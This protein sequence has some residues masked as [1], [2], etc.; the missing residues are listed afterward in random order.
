M[1]FNFYNMKNLIQTSLV[2]AGL[3]L[4]AFNANAA[5]RTWTGGAVLNDL[6]SDKDNW[7]G[8]VAPVSGDR[9]VF[10]AG[11]QDSDKGMLNTF[12]S[13]TVFQRLTFNAAGYTVSGTAVRLSG[14]MVLEYGVLD[15]E[16]R[17]DVPL[18]LTASQ[19]LDRLE[20][21]PTLHLRPGLTGPAL[22]L[23]A[24][25]LTVTGDGR[26]I[27]EGEV[28][29]TGGLTVEGYEVDL[30]RANS[31]TGLTLIQSNGILTLTDFDVAFAPPTLGSTAGPTHVHG[32]LDFAFGRDV[33]VAEPLKIFDGGMVVAT[34]FEAAN[35]GVVTHT[36]SLELGGPGR[37][38][39][40]VT[41]SAPQVLF[42]VNGVISGNGD[43]VK[44][45]DPNAAI[46]D[47]Q[48]LSIGG[49]QPNSFAG[50]YHAQANTTFLAKPTGV[51]ALSCASVFIDPPY[52]LTSRLRL[53]ASHQIAD[54][55]HVI[56]Q[57]RGTF[58]LQTR[59]ETIRALTLAGGAVNGNAPGQLDVTENIFSTPA[60]QSGL[61]NA[62]VHLYA[63]PCEINVL[64]GP[65]LEDLIFTGTIVDEAGASIRK[66]GPGRVNFT[67][68]AT[69]PVEIVEGAVV[70]QR[71]PGSRI[72]LNGG[73]LAGSGEIGLLTSL[74]GGGRV[75]PGYSIGII[76]NTTIAW[77]S[78]TTY[79]VEVLNATP[80][81]GHDQLRVL[82]G[83]V[84]LGGAHLEV[85]T[86]PGFG[87]ALGQEF[88]IIDNDGSDAIT[89]TFAGLTNGAE[90]A[91]A[92]GAK[93]TVHYNGG[94]GNDVSLRTTFVPPTGVT[95]LWTGD[96]LT[97][98]W[99]SGANW[100]AAI[101]PGDRLQFPNSAQ[102]NML[103][104]LPAFTP[105]DTL[106][107]SSAGYK[108]RG[109]P[110]ALINGL[111]ANFVGVPMLLSNQF[112]LLASNTTFALSGSAQ[113]E[114]HRPTSPGSGVT[115]DLGNNVL[116]LDTASG[117]TRLMFE[118]GESV[119][120]GAGLVVKQGIGFLQLRG[121]SPDFTGA[122]RV[123]AGTL[124]LQD[125]VNVLGSL[126]TAT[127]TVQASATLDMAFIG[128]LS[129]PQTVRLEAGARLRSSGGVHSL[130][131]PL[132][133]TG[134]PTRPIIEVAD[135]TLRFNQP[136]SGTNGLRKTGAGELVFQGAAPNT[137][138]GPLLVEAGLLTLQKTPGVAA[139]GGQAQ[140]VGGVLRLGNGS[141]FPAGSGLTVNAPG[142]FDLNTRSE[143][144]QGG[145]GLILQGGVVSNGTLNVI[146]NLSTLA[147]PTA[148]RIEGILRVVGDPLWTVN[149]GA[150]EDDLIVNA[151]VGTQVN[152]NV[153]RA[154]G[155]RLVFAGTNTFSSL[156]L[157]AGLT[158]INGSNTTRVDLN[159]GTLGG[160][161][162]LANLTSL[163]GGGIV[164]PGASTGILS[165][166]NVSW[167]AATTFAPEIRT[168][169]PGAGHDQL[170]VFGSV[171]LGGATLDVTVLSNFT[172]TTSDTIVL[173][174]N[175]GTEAITN[176]FAG[177][178]EGAT[179]TEAELGAGTPRSFRISYV[180]GA[181]SNDVTLKLLV[182]G[183]GLTRTWDGGGTNNNWSVSTN[184]DGNLTAPAA[185]DA[186]VFPIGAARLLNT[187]NFAAGTGFDSITIRSNGY[188]LR[189]NRVSLIQ[190]LVFDHSASSTL[191]LPITLTQP[192]SFTAVNDAFGIVAPQG[193]GA[194]L[195]NA[196]F[197]LTLRPD[198]ALSRVD[199]SG[200]TGSGALVKNGPGLSA[201]TLNTHSGLTTINEG[202]VLLTLSADGLGTTA[203]A[204]VVNANALVQFS[205]VTAPTLA[206]PFKLAG[207]LAF[208]NSPVALTAP[209][210]LVGGALATFHVSSSTPFL[211]GAISGSG[212][213]QKTG[214][215]ELILDGSAA[216][217][218]T[219]GTTIA[220]GVLHLQKTAGIAALPGPVFITGGGGSAELRLG[221]ANQI[222]DT[223]SLTLDGAGALFNLNDH[224]ETV[225]DVT[226][227]GGSILTGTGQLSLA[228]PLT[229]LASTNTASLDGAVDVQDGAA[230]LVED[231]S[232]AND[233]VASAVISGKEGTTLVKAGAG[234]AVFSGNNSLPFLRIDE[235]DAA[236]THDSSA[237]IAILNG[238]TLSGDGL[239]GG[240]TNLPPGGILAPGDGL[241]TLTSTGA[242][243]LIEKTVFAIELL[244]GTPAT[245]YDTLA[246]QG[247]V[248]LGFADL[249][250]TLLPGFTPIPGQRFT[251]L[252]NQGRDNVV[253]EFA[254]LAEGTELDLGAVRF[255][256]SYKGGDGNDVVL[257]TSPIPSTGVTNRWDGG[258]GVSDTKWTTA[259]NWEDDLA[260]EQGNVLLFP[261]GPAQ[262]NT[263][264]DFPA[265]TTFPLIR[266]EG[267]NYTLAG[268]RVVLNDGVYVAA[269]T[270]EAGVVVSLPLQLAQSQTFTLA[271]N[272][273]VLSGGLDTDDHTLT[274]EI[275]PTAQCT[276]ST[277]PIS[278]NGGVTKTGLGELFLSG[279]N[280]YAGTTLLQGGR[281]IVTT[282][283]ALGGAG[284]TTIQ[285][286]ELEFRNAIPMTNSESI[287]LTA[288]NSVL[289][290]TNSHTLTGVITLSGTGAREI[291]VAP[292][293][294]LTLNGR[295]A[296]AGALRKT[297][298]GQLRLGG[299]LANTFTG[300]TTVEAGS[301]T[302]SK[303]TSN[304]IPGAL[305]LGIPGGPAILATLLSS[306]QIA[307]AAIV[308]LRAGSQLSFGTFADTIGGL[309]LQDSTVS[310]ATNG[311]L[312]I[313]GNVQCLATPP[314]TIGISSSISG[315]V[316]ITGGVRT[317]NVE[318][319]LFAE[320]LDVDAI[321]STGAGASLLKTGPGTLR[322]LKPTTISQAQLDAGSTFFDLV[323]SSTLIQL[324]G[325]LLAG[326][327]SVSH[328]TSL[329]GGG[330]VSPGFGI[331]ALTCSNVTWNAATTYRYELDGTP[332]ERLNALGPVNLG[333][334][335]LFIRM[336]NILP[337][338]NTS[339]PLILNESGQPI[340]GTFAG[341]PEGALFAANGVIFQISYVG[342]TAA[343]TDGNDVQITRVAAP[344][345][346]LSG[347][348]TRPD[349]FAQFTITG[350]P[351][352]EYIVEA[353]TDFITW[354]LIASVTAGGNGLGQFI[355]PDSLL[356][357]HRF[358]RA[359]SP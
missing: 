94:D 97:N 7:S 166:S 304:A 63:H 287:T 282:A 96:A 150:A 6:W 291:R 279:N 107:I 244:N 196:G 350:V 141:Q 324:N 145:A 187:N 11:I 190:G 104:D 27:V 20:G 28:I 15:G 239:I 152:D 220:G 295:I 263:T 236:I 258:A 205:L 347:L 79:E 314:L 336:G 322:F 71:A 137:F 57:E 148:A 59:F 60:D 185:G 125:N 191:N 290:T 120:R 313:N 286:A 201:L 82:L 99:S 285:A 271:T 221:S 298:P 253:N 318:G 261:T 341:L 218:F 240:I 12:G 106:I 13:G 162:R 41:A 255:R 231:G 299:S 39:L 51:T 266:I 134:G 67:E 100:S 192:Q 36:G 289:L 34:S 317:W 143:T 325:G 204:T 294:T 155:G 273:L 43:L 197:T 311:L 194:S 276:V 281:T 135:Q 208:L 323:N 297:N 123:E 249:S 10:P 275:E 54:T 243:T 207:T 310:T 178:A 267:G 316:Q 24:H 352:A 338:L 300:G 86:L 124:A 210:T 179:F 161:G 332:N 235:G 284:G 70:V 211:R 128:A 227:T 74:A 1:K 44:E 171:N 38:A 156:R 268:N 312:T 118:G 245:G 95:R 50:S 265:G 158:L 78:A 126:S 103:N 29:G 81:T 116:N 42:H 47:Q 151:N 288:T 200:L 62:E 154:G 342:A 129:V 35:I 306:N 119:F 340:T 138:T 237:M 308:T 130:D 105:F 181:G 345:S 92:S 355:D 169:T 234:R 157:D 303:T 203:G 176:T 25:T 80:G 246:V 83:G 167:N 19:T 259:A 189:G 49:T 72:S 163:A 254:G 53:D 31:Y 232:L 186:L 198:S 343:G 209:M 213:C 339:F 262:R 40:R 115:F 170:R 238:G 84:D 110:L 139:F 16:V 224:D 172:A 159:G 309:A 195:D 93:F 277:L 113:L 21:A 177:L 359:V 102:Y 320:E 32:E 226:F 326:N 233:F 69:V 180:G 329:A 14:G 305:A 58:D 331:G 140:V 174:D 136:V 307:D 45:P 88:V 214:A 64:D 344:P 55:A 91:T 292:L 230:W 147:S 280:T 173:I 8:D 337:A 75:A 122:F 223:A 23:G 293:A 164:A 175:D 315:R 358:Y 327:G 270:N 2:L 77:N 153:R 193:A 248:D 46:N 216:N 319:G 87:T 165:V 242:V 101:H 109:N 199:V 90:F 149:D 65:P 301:L 283:G 222:A 256:I 260:P 114:F 121:R 26:V 264:N 48:D 68:L 4:A 225:N 229:S 188:T 18:R 182:L 184:W 61:V 330:T 117:T 73:T 56:V 112:L 131:G 212:G 250:V 217:T 144:I 241:G 228:G 296:G 89:N 183:T 302:L 274:L 33:E 133:V 272:A 215:G 351:G 356:F 357:P 17:F 85:I 3:A 111:T 5:T 333:G 257:T 354:Q 66:T 30:R 98:T 269:P 168:A 321:V 335:A 348:T 251:I 22:D 353:S 37:M 346:L 349:G 108:L 247:P 132:L 334:A 206:E 202:S 9:L 278:G 142:Q 328:V 146:G 160:T 127:A 76:T 52:G 252:D 219:G